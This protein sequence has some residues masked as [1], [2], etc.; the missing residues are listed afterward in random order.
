VRN[1][2]NDPDLAWLADHREIHIIAQQN[3]DGRRQVEQGAGLWRKNH[4]ETACPAF[5]PGVDLNRNSPFLWGNGSSGNACSEVYRG[6]Q[7]SS[8]PETRAV[9]DYLATVFQRQRPGD[10]LDDPAPDDAEGLFVSLHSFSELVLLPWDGLGGQNENNA[11]NHDQLTILGRRFG[12]LTDYAVGRWQLLPPAG[13]TMTD[14][15]YAEFGVA[16]YTFEVG[17]TFMQSCD[18]FEATLWPVNFQALKLAAKA[19]RRPFLEPAGPAITALSANLENG[20]IRITGI[21]DDTRYF[22]GN[23]TEPPTDDPIAEVVEIRITAGL[24]ESA[25]G[26]PLLFAIDSPA[27]VASFEFVLPD[28]VT[29]PVNGRLFASAVDSLGRTGLPRVVELAERLLFADGFE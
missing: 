8:E 21:A 2:E 12:F 23:V 7:A 17:T 3:P 10:G 13:G 27:S 19:A 4:N 26:K 25:G 5:T 20:R 16:S 1:P 18:S 29:L 9:Q 22:R 6:D 11:P 14:F 28:G 15:A 24:P